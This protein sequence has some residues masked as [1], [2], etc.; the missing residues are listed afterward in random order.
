M[1]F[2]PTHQMP[3]GERGC[4]Q[5]QRDTVLSRQ[6]E[7]GLFRRLALKIVV[8]FVVALAAVVLLW[9]EKKPPATLDPLGFRGAIEKVESV[10]YSPDRLTFEHRMTLRSGLGEL[11]TGLRQTLPSRAQRDALE[12]LEPFCLMTGVES[13][14]QDFDVVATRK[15]WEELR[16]AHFRPAPWFRRGT[17]RLEQAQTSDAAR[18]IPA[19]AHL[20]QPALDQIKLLAARVES[21]LESLPE[22]SGDLDQSG[23]ESWQGARRD[24]QLD[25]ERLKPQL[26]STF[27]GMDSGWRQAQRDLVR[28]MEALPRML[29]PDPYGHA[30]VPGASQG[31]GRIR[32]G[33]MTIERAQA[34]LDAA[35][36]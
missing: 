26:P 14:L 18:G 7:R 20:Y 21:V 16:A 24:L 23:Y 25:L 27:E 1:T 13:D 2:C 17:V 6:E 28:A 12:R 15:R 5:C 31:R 33:R 10:L 9:P 8:P 36:R 34:S 22:D 19:D 30:L 3:W 35:P 32:S 29:G 4:P 11:Q